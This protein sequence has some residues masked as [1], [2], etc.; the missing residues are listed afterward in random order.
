MLP[1]IYDFKKIKNKYIKL[2]LSC[3][4][5]IPDMVPS[6]EKNI[7]KVYWDYL[8][9]N[10]NAIHILEKNLDNVDWIWLSRNPNA[11]PIL[12]KNLDKVNWITL[13]INPNAI[14]IL[15]KNLD[16]VYWEMLSKNQNI[17]QMF[18][19][20]LLDYEKMRERNKLFA[21]ELTSKVF[22][23]MRLMNICETYN[24]EFEDLIDNVY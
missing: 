8:S 20:D 18:P 15:E 22:N 4:S 23:P 11:I 3:L 1:L 10:P 17:T 14:H 13:S 16:K 2:N 24:C 9:G 7:D 12:E 21:E 19:L 6:L 5:L